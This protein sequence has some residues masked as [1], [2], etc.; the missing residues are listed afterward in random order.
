MKTISRLPRKADDALLDARV[1]RIWRQV[2]D[3]DTI[4]LDDSFFDSGGD[5]LG[6]LRL[7]A[8][9]RE[10]LNI[11]LP[12]EDLFG[13]PTP[14]AVAARIRSIE[15]HRVDSSETV[16]RRRSLGN[17]NLPVTWN[18]EE[19]LQRE[20]QAGP[21]PKNM[22]FSLRLEGALDVDAVEDALAL[23]VD[24]HDVLRSAFF[25]RGGAP[26]HRV[27]DSKRPH[28]DW[29][30]LTNRTAEEREDRTRLEAAEVVREPFDLESGLLCR[31]AVWRLA[32]EDHV[33]V[34]C[35][36]QLVADGWAMGVLLQQLA[37]AYT[38]IARGGPTEPPE[39]EL[40]FADFAA[41]E[42]ETYPLNVVSPIVNE[43]RRDLLDPIE[44]APRLVLPELAAEVEASGRLTASVDVPPEI[45]KSARANAQ[46]DGATTF[47]TAVA[48]LVS[49]L[50]DAS[51]ADRIGAFIHAANRRWP[52]S[53]SLPGWF[54]NRL[55]LTTDI[56]AHDTARD[57]LRRMRTALTRAL[58][59]ETFPWPCFL[60]YAFPGE[61]GRPAT[62]PYVRIQHNP[63]SAAATS[64]R[65]AALGTET[66]PLRSAGV[67]EAAVVY[68]PVERGDALRLVI[69]YA[70]PAIPDAR[71]PS[72]LD[73]CVSYLNALATA[74]DDVLR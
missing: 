50:A 35:A 1:L 37:T 60:A 24:R 26:Y 6:A 72:L 30:D 3:A 57:L 13:H 12:L 74:P 55:L 17:D 44:S 42:R 71:A 8:A 27:A 52:A 38:A 68:E 73:S 51:A 61:Y 41:W 39:I 28:V 59:R 46:L 22:H 53:Q 69:S 18:Q 43:L 70:T 64:P 14:R 4:E 10:E 31:A 67:S 29:H 48:A 33:L 21:R 23:L 63:V 56:C 11:V 36:E 34:V 20:L 49:A 2:L 5:S 40:R 45:W 15:E 65:F 66:F 25:R 58:G 19:R 54:A 62:I 7:I 47:C 16:P 9:L 32:A